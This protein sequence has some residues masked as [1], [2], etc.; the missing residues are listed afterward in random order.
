MMYV[1]GDDQ[2][3]LLN[4]WVLFFVSYDVY[5]RSFFPFFLV[6]CLWVPPRGGG[7]TTQKTE[8]CLCSR[9]FLLGF[10]I[11][12]LISIQCLIICFLFMGPEKLQDKLYRFCSSRNWGLLMGA[13]KQKWKAEEEAA[14]KA[15]VIKHGAGKWRTILTDPEFSGILH[16]RSNVD[17]KVSVLDLQ[18]V[19]PTIIEES[20]IY[21]FSCDALEL[22]PMDSASICCI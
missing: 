8:F 7:G 21:T 9:Y 17:L 11:C 13:P 4:C 18:T 2:I 20:V 3:K 6:F 16:L 15:G 14:L 10:C 22:V 19:L 12:L 5:Y 1:E